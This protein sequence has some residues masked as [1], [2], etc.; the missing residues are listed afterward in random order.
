[1]DP[2]ALPPCQ[3]DPAAL[4]PLIMTSDPGSFAHNTLKVRVP[5]ILQ[6]TISLNTF[7]VEIR[8]ALDEMYDELTAG[9]VRGLREDA[10][11][12]AFWDAVCAPWLGRS[13][14][15]VP[16]YWAEAYFYRRILEAT[17][18]FQPGPW[19]GFDP[20]AVKKR[21]EWAADAAPQAVERLLRRLPHDPHD[22]FVRLLHASLWGNRTDLSYQVAAHLGRADGSRDERDNLLV[23]DTE[24]VWRFLT[25]VAQA[26]SLR[27][28]VIADNAGAE[29]LMDLALIDGLL[30]GGLVAEVHLHLKPQPFFVSDAMPRD[31]MDGLD[32]LAAGGE[33]AAEL[34]GRLRAY[35]ADG[36][37]QL[38]AHWLYATSL[39]YF[40]LPADLSA[41]LAGTALVI[42]K[43]DA[44]YRRLLG[45]AHWPATTPF[46]QAVSYFPAPLVALRTLKGEIIVG[47]A[48]GHARRLAAEDPAWLVNGQRGVIQAKLGRARRSKHVSQSVR[49]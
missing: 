34:A 39:F 20:Y 41:E 43:G 14:L 42:V 33:A 44:N 7:P 23:D 49:A 1:M 36:R 48:K 15:A 8:A 29:L 9:T 46:A 18:Y 28:I 10:A 31:V 19:R 25:A 47:L 45:D 13:W 21:T 24:A 3:V 32:A 26:A 16:W 12:R 5:A 17:R 38:A 27:Y 22:R 30:A 37:L 35:L 2:F 40:Q 11:D 6:E 4:P